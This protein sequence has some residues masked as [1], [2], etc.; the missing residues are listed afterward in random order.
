MSLWRRVTV[1]AGSFIVITTITTLLMQAQQRGNPV[2]AAPQAGA[3]PER[4]ATPVPPEKSS[5]TP[6]EM[7]LDGKTLK[8]FATAG[9]LNIQGED[10]QTNASVFY[11]AYTLDGVTDTR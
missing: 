3:T 4:P 1:F 7:V 6:H 10:E 11:V 9:H 2:N 8:Y 5:I